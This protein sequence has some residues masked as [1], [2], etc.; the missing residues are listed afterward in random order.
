ME[1]NVTARRGLKEFRDLEA[2]LLEIERKLDDHQ[3]ALVRGGFDRAHRLFEE[4]RAAVRRHVEDEEALLL[5]LYEE[6]VRPEPGGS[7]APFRAEH[8]E[9]DRMM[10][11]ID[12]RLR[13]LEDIKVPADANDL[14][15]CFEQEFELKRLWLAHSLRER[16]ILFPA[17]DAAT[18]VDEREWLL[19]KCDA[20]E[21][22]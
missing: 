4:Y 14:I 20:R 16:N 19:S 10:E 13:R 3:L 11:S 1:A 2:V 15:R 12:A 18:E 5:P 7:G 17:L 9:L 22:R 6:R 21:A 8:A